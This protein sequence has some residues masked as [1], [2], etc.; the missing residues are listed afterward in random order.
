MKPAAP[1]TPEAAELRLSARS[2]RRPRPLVSGD[3]TPFRGM[4]EA[5]ETQEDAARLSLGR[6]GT[7]ARRRVQLVREEGRDVSS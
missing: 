1:S 6:G 3:P 2:E 4:A 5:L 7:V